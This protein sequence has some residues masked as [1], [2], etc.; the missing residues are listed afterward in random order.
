[1]ACGADWAREHANA[2]FPSH[3]HLAILPS[4][5]SLASP[6]RDSPQTSASLGVWH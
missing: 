3:Q 1:M 2:K 5:A 6:E 4:K